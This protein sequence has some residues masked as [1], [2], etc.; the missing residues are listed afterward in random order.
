M[1]T[2]DLGALTIP[3]FAA[4]FGA[5]WLACVRILVQ[6]MKER[7]SALEARLAEI[8]KERDTRLA[9]LEAGLIVR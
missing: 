2:V 3:A 1:P 5:G 8:E 6:P 4:I 9:M 7:L